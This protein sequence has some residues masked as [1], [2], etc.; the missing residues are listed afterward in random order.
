MSSDEGEG[1]AIYSDD[2]NSEKRQSIMS[3]GRM[4]YNVGSVAEEP[5][6]TENNE[7]KPHQQEDTTV[8]SDKVEVHTE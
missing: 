8:N 3:G 7:V 2:S 1:P 6:F 5:K 4:S